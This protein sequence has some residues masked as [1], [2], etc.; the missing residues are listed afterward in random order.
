MPLEEP[1]SVEVQIAANLLG[2]PKDAHS[3]TYLHG[4]P[5]V[6]GLNPASCQQ[7]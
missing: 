4:K 7:L 3:K 2:T 6:A 1:Y 5:W